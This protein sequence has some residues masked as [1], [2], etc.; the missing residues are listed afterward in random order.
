MWLE[1]VIRAAELRD[2]VRGKRRRGVHSLSESIINAKSRGI[3]PIIAELKRAS[4][5]GFSS[6]LNPHKY[7]KF[8]ESAGAIALSVITE[9]VA[10]NGSYSL[11]RSVS[12]EVNMPILMKDFIVTEGQVQD[13]YVLGADAV[14]LIVRVVNDGERLKHLYS[15]AQSM[16]IEC[17]VEVHSDDDLELALNL[18]PRI[19]GVNA[20]NLQTLEM[21]FEQQERILKA[22]PS[23]VLRVAESGIESVERINRLKEFGADGFLIGTS[24]MKNPEMIFKYLGRT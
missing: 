14:L 13:A 12:S 22:L 4:P 24:L 7:V 15:M 9:P 16:G 21:N 23:S 1:K 6:N 18:K 8:V 17:V 20:R 11:L 2:R 3:N 10:F 5:S 19:I